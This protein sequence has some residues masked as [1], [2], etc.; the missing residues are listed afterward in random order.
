MRPRRLP[1]DAS[2]R[3]SIWAFCIGS[4]AAIIV[5][6]AVMARA[7]IPTDI[8]IRNPIAWVIAAIVGAFTASRG[9]LG[10]PLIA[11]VVLL[12]G[13]S[14]IGPGQEG[15]HRWV[16]A[17]PAQLNAAALAL[18]LA[19][20]VFT[21]ER[22]WLAVSAFVA[23]G[24]V[25]AYQPDISQ[26][27][28]LMLASI[29]LF[30]TAFGWVG[31]LAA[32]LVGGGLIAYCVLLR[33]DPLLPVEHVEGILALAAGQSQV[34]GVALPVALGVACLS[35]L[36]LW[37]SADLRWRG[38]ALAAYFSAAALAPL[39]GAYPVPLAGYGFSFVAG[40]VLGFA[41][42]ATRKSINSLTLG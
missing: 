20:A 10:F 35:P 34:S 5:G 17:G 27:A 36:L 22:R 14:L 8:W 33:P 18:P 1:D 4:L 11:L 41:A 29:V 25:I 16:G 39:F 21:P 26:L 37:R 40:W 13:A 28:A 42:L 38:L 2:H 9:W 6:A 31:G 3:P 32:L 15:V 23:I 12:I 7:D 30:S 19:I 24:A